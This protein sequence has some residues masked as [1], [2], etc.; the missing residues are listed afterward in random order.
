M[1]SCTLYII[2]VIVCWLVRSHVMS[3]EIN[4]QNDDNL[5]IRF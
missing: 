5:D 4:T 1:Y 3:H 2:S